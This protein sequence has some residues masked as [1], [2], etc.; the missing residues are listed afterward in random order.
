MIC[1]C[2]THEIGDHPA[3]AQPCSQFTLLEWEH[4]HAWGGRAYIMLYTLYT[5]YVYV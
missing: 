5:I 2:C 3:V 1:H 4:R